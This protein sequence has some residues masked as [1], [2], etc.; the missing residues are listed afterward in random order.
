MALKRHV[1]CI[2]RHVKAPTEAVWIGD[3]ILD[4]AIYHFV[5]SSN[6]RRNAAMVPGPLEARKRAAKRRMMNLARAGGAGQI[7]PS[8]LD[9]LNGRAQKGNWQWQSPTPSAPKD[10]EGGLTL[11]ALTES[12][13]LTLRQSLPLC[14][15]GSPA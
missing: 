6:G 7:D 13:I 3:D 11:N 1:C 9:G 4:Y 14:L 5:R 15:R 12:E 8:L 10:L 2:P